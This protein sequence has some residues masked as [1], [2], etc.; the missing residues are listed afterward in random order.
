MFE[1]LKRCDWAAWRG[2][3]AAAVEDSGQ[4]EILNWSCLAGAMSE[5][6]R[7]AEGNR[8]PR[9]LDLQFDQGVPDRAAGP[10]RGLINAEP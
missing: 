1:A 9:H 5:L 7:Q 3:S 2:M 6:G 4:Q 8:L 10:G